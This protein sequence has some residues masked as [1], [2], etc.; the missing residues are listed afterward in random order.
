MI[1]LK[2]AS[3][4]PVPFSSVVGQSIALKNAA[5]RVIGQIAIL[6]LPAGADYKTGSQ[7]IARQIVDAFEE[8]DRHKAVTEN[9]HLLSTSQKSK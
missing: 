3:I 8:R 2:I 5:G 7:D 9:L 1:D 6:N 4:E